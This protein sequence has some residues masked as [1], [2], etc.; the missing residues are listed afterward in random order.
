MLLVVWPAGQ[1]R[2]E[3]EPGL[4]WYLLTGQEVQAPA[5]AYS[6]AGQSVQSARRAEPV[7]E[8]VWP[9]G[10]SRQEVEAAA[11]WYLEAGHATHPLGAQSL[12]PV[13]VERDSMQY[14]LE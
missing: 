10:Q 13:Q 6:P 2:Q 3:V 5:E 8:V 1:S 4:G 12:K 7:P 11:G 14:S 9:A